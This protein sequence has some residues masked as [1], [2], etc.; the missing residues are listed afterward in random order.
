MCLGDASFYFEKIFTQ[1][2]IISVFLF[3]YKKAPN[4]P[5]VHLTKEKKS[6]EFLWLLFAADKYS[7]VTNQM[8]EKLS[9]IDDIKIRLRRY[10]SIC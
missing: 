5:K 9:S 10:G 3:F 4:A 7:H 8:R 1:C 2:Q 6:F